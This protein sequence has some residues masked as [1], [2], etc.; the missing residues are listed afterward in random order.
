MPGGHEL[1]F[2]N[3]KQNGDGVERGGRGRRR[4][5]GLRKLRNEVHLQ[6]KIAGRHRSQALLC[7]LGIAFGILLVLEGSLEIKRFVAVLERQPHVGVLTTVFQPQ[8]KIARTVQDSVHRRRFLWVI[9]HGAGGKERAGLWTLD[10]FQKHDR[11]FAFDHDPQP[12]VPNGRAV[13]VFSAVALRRR[14][15]R[16]LANENLFNLQN[17]QL[18]PQKQKQNER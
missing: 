18:P 2:G 15:R 3:R 16:H 11:L 9:V 17:G 13:P 6:R 4:R 7:P 5:R 8:D 10:V 14:Q 12:P 1:T